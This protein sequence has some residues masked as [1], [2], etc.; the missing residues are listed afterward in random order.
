MLPC[1]GSCGLTSVGVKLSRKRFGI[2]S[3]GDTG[4]VSAEIATLNVKDKDDDVTLPGFFG[5]QDVKIV[6]SHQW[7]PVMLGKGK[8]SEQGAKAVLDGKMNLDEA[9]AEARAVHSRLKFDL[10]NPPPLIEWSYG[11]ELKTG[12]REQFIDDEKFGDGYW[13]Q[14][15][16]GKPGAKVFEASPVLVGAGEGTGTTAVKSAGQ[17][18]SILDALSELGDDEA[19]QL[20]ELHNL[21]DL[22]QED[23]KFIDQLDRTLAAVRAVAKRADEIT[24]ERPLGRDSAERTREIA[25][26]LN[27]A[28]K[29]L[30]GV[31]ADADLGLALPTEGELALLL[32]QTEARM[33]GRAYAR[34]NN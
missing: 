9:D 23:Q 27:E 7:G 24:D 1:G 30:R 2:K 31:T 32:A 4:E 10:D 8:I 17:T 5:E 3:L 16:D 21:L 26:A 19:K 14:P 33:T 6:L 25:D 22:K 29:K 28:E 20:L 12:G 11:F 18:L 13:L 15:V 34:T